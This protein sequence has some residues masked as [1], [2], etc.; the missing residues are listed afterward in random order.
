MVGEVDR[1]GTQRLGLPASR[2]GLEAE[3]GGV[4]EG[5]DGHGSAAVG[6]I[7]AADA[8]IELNEDAEEVL[9]GD[10]PGVAGGLDASH[11]E[12]VLG[13][14]L[15]LDALLLLE[16]GDLVLD[17]VEGEVHL[18]LPFGHSG[19][20]TLDG[21]VDEAVSVGVRMVADVD[22]ADLL[23]E[24]GD[25]VGV[26]LAVLVVHAHMTLGHFVRQEDVLVENRG[27]RGSSLVNAAPGLD[28]AGL[29]LGVTGHQV[30]GLLADDERLLEFH[31]V[32][33]VV[34]VELRL[35]VVLD[36]RLGLLARVLVLE[37]QGGGNVVRK[38]CR[39]LH[40]VDTRLEHAVLDLE[41]VRLVLEELLGVFEPFVPLDGAVLAEEVALLLLPVAGEGDL[42]AALELELDVGALNG[43]HDLHVDH[44]LD[45]VAWL[46]EG[47]LRLQLD[48]ALGEGAATVREKEHNFIYNN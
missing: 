39:E 27:H 19:V 42:L 41:N 7:S 5:Y 24:E 32:V 16:L 29:L 48:L 40:L 2:G 25:A 8:A 37:V 33:L 14:D 4:D 6:E 30:D 11:H 1:E 44:A 21:L 22:G 45:G 26:Q 10:F 31:V 18:G 28:V 43:L 47:V 15:L 23:H 3:A 38:L 17:V 12:G 34:A 9:V 20:G 46:V 36:L 13:R 35:D